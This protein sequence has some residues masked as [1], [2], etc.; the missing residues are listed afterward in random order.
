MAKVCHEIG[1][2]FY[3]NIQCAES[4]TDF[5]NIKHL[6]FKK[7]KIKEINTPMNKYNNNNK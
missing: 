2:C 7:R 4:P 6:Q 3:V 5:S 1:M